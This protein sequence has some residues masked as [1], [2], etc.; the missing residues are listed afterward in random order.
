MKRGKVFSL[1]GRET[2]KSILQNMKERSKASLSKEKW[3]TLGF[4]HLEPALL[5]ANSHHPPH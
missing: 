4:D 2:R 1:R 5:R 3:L